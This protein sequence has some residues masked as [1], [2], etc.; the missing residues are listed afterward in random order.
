MSVVIGD[1]YGGEGSFT[2]RNTCAYQ[3]CCIQSII[4]VILWERETLIIKST[5]Q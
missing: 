2:F 1:N 5:T 4:C 3:Q